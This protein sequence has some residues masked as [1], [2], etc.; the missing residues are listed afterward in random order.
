[1]EQKLT[2]EE[3]EYIRNLWT[4]APLH[5]NNH[6]IL[7]HIKYMPDSD[8]YMLCNWYDDGPFEGTMPKDWR[9]ERDNVEVKV[10]CQRKGLGYII[11]IHNGDVNLQRNGMRSHLGTAAYAFQFYR[12]YNYAFPIYLERGHWANRKMPFELGIAVPDRQSLYD[13]LKVLFDHDDALTKQWF[14]DKELAGVD[15]NDWNVFDEELTKV[16]KL[17]TGKR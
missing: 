15:L 11:D 3:R 9:I 12:A 5:N 17:L 7:K 1:M 16:N 6:L 10:F 4:W 13:A 2:P 14:F 8:V